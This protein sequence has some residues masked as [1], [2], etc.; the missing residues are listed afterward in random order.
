MPDRPFFVKLEMDGR[1][2]AALERNH[3]CNKEASI[4]YT[5]LLSAF[6]VE[7]RTLILT[8]Y[9][10]KRGLSPEQKELFINMGVEHTVMKEYHH[11]VDMQFQFVETLIDQAVGTE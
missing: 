2:N 4:G 7:S 8:A 5:F 10:C 1:T 11:S 3:F 9:F 6:E